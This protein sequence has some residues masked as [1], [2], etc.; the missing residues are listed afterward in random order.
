MF[1]DWNQVRRRVTARLDTASES[2]WFRI[3]VAVLL[4]SFHLAMFAKAGHERLGLPFNTSKAEAPYFA[5][6]HATSTIGYP[7]EPRHWSR[8][9]VSR[10]DAQHYIEMSVRGLSVCPTDKSAP[11]MEY[12]ECGLGWLP[13]WGKF[14]GTI[15]AM[16]GIDDDIVLVFLS[17]FATIAINLMWI[18]PLITKR[19]GKPEAYA[20]AIAFTVFP[21]AFHLVTP[22]TEAATLALVLGALF[23]LSEERWILAGALVGAATALKISAA[24]F[25][26][27]LGCAALYAAWRRREKAVT[28]WWWPL[29]ALPLCGWGQIVEMILI[30]IYTGD[31]M[32]FWRARDAF[33]DP[34]DFSRLTDSEYF[35]KGFS[36]QHMDIVILLGVLAIVALTARDVL[37]KL[38]REE[39]VYIGIASAVS[40]AMVVVAPLIYWGISRYLLLVPL[41]FLGMGSMVR[42][43]PAV[44]VMWLLLCLAFYWN[45]ELCSY[46]AQGDPRLCPCLGRVEFYFPFGS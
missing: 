6:I 45:I 31:A 32:A 36:A 46:V 43:H 16:T 15:S 20:T 27:G 17:V 4:A 33:G 7:R 14:G 34:H 5:N 8:L 29:L 28:R 18:S 24:A 35:L 42:K 22:Y 12:L 19:L 13:A 39:A 37:R 11:D 23:A 26:I 9:I 44:F 25:G 1:T 40:L 21:S 2:Q 38:T 41:A 30:R 3:A 10:W